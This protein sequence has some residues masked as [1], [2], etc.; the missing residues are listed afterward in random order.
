M[1]TKEQKIA[2]IEAAEEKSRR[3]KEDRKAFTPHAGQLD[4]INDPHKIRVVTC[5]NGWGKTAYGVN[6]AVWAA[7]G[8]NPVTKKTAHVPARVYVVLDAP[9]KVEEVWLREIKKWYPLK[10]EQLHKLGKP[11]VSMI[12]FPNGSQIRFMFHLQEDLAFESVEADFVVFD[13]PPPRSIWVALLR[14]GRNAKS[15]PRYLLLGT[16]IAQAWLR[17]YNT[18]WKKGRFPDTMFFKYHTEQNKENLTK[19]YIESFSMHLTENEKRTRLEGEWFNTEGL[20]LAHLFDRKHH[21][22]PSTYPEATS[23]PCVL[24][25][26]PHPNKPTTACLL[27]IDAAGT[28]HYLAELNQKLEPRRLAMWLKQNWIGKYNIVDFVCDSS[29]SADYTGGSG[30]K[31]FIEVLNEE[32][33]RIRAT[34]YDEKKDDDFLERI[35]DALYIGPSGASKLKILNNCIGLIKDIENC[36]WQPI[37]NSETYKPKLEIGNRDFLACL[38][39]ALAVNLTFDS[40]S[41]K[42]RASYSKRSSFMGKKGRHGRIERNWSQQSDDSDG[43]DW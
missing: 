26:D 12:Q 32:G 11:F 18:E 14:G 25:I 38:K 13:E 36:S 5:G 39:Y 37:K 41:R 31:S 1:L 20:A 17:E 42:V 43:D 7:L 10:E 30:F 16:P 19:G 2:L 29:G 35:Q 15:N 23:V 34:T 3:K 9:S 4:V 21:L 6:E 22:I 28:Y 8:Y 40:S 24:S 33:I 27:G